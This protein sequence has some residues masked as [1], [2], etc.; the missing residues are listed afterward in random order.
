HGVYLRPR[1]ATPAAVALLGHPV[2]D[3][4]DRVLGDD[5]RMPFP[6]LA[7]APD[8]HRLARLDGCR[9]IDTTPTPIVGA[10]HGQE[11][12]NKERAADHHSGLHGEPLSFPRGSPRTLK[13][14]SSTYPV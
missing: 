3:A 2:R 8:P 6:D 9:L 7:A 1:K 5:H 14:T 4:R 11:D 12:R 10:A 13:P